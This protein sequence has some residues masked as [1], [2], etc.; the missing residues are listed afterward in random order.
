[1]TKRL[2]SGARGVVDWRTMKSLTDALLYGILDL[3]YTAAADAERDE[4]GDARPARRGAFALQRGLQLLRVLDG[5]LF[6]TVEMFRFGGRV[7]QRGDELFIVV[8][9]EKAATTMKSSSPR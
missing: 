8:A 3:G 7:F 5:F 1:M 4:F 9:D 2:A 6:K